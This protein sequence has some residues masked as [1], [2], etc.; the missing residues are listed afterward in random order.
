MIFGYPLPRP[1]R[2]I[3]PICDRFGFQFCSI[4]LPIQLSFYRPG[5]VRAA[6]F[7]K[8]RHLCIMVTMAY[9]MHYVTVLLLLFEAVHGDSWRQSKVPDPRCL[10]LARRGELGAIGENGDAEDSIHMPF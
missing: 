4:V 9:H 1:L 7:S 5:G 2:Q 3:G 10:I 6:R 8:W